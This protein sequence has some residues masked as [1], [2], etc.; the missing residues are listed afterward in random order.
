MPTI[1]TVRTAIADTVGAAIPGLI[2]Y[3]TVADVVQVPAMVVRPEKCDYVVGMGTC[4]QWVFRLYV[5]VPHTETNANQDQLDAY[6]STS[7]TNSIPAA[8][9]ANP[10]FGVPGVDGLLTEMTGYGG[11]W[12]AAKVPHIGAQLTLRVLITE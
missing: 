9:R 10:S 5:L 6:L 4:Q 2:C 1:R 3:R 12:D 8:V 7:G 11:T